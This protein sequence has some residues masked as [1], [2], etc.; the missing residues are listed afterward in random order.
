MIR[1]YIWN[2]YALSC[3]KISVNEADHLPTEIIFCKKIRK[4]EEI[5]TIYRSGKIGFYFHRRLLFPPFI[6]T[7]ANNISVQEVC[8][9]LWKTFILIKRNKFD[10]SNINKGRYIITIFLFRITIG[11]GMRL[12]Q[13][14]SHFSK[15]AG[16]S[17][18]FHFPLR[19]KLLCYVW[20][21]SKTQ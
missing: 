7:R 17:R 16:P 21:S 6:C 12:L 15:C 20:K 9:P 3:L 4:V 11:E 10:S 2:I 5:L 1:N 8:G 18:T 19:Y 13:F 14:W